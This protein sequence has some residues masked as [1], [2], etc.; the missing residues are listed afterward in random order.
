MAHRQFVVAQ[1]HVHS[2]PT[3]RVHLAPAG[4]GRGA[5]RSRQLRAERN[6]AAQHRVGQPGRPAGQGAA[7]RRAGAGAGR[8]Q[9]RFGRDRHRPRR[10][11]APMAGCHAA[12]RR[13]AVGGRFR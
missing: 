12:A 6:W 11:G 4:A 2:I 1:R 5:V 9:R 13:A 7:R 10:Q 3:A 8:A